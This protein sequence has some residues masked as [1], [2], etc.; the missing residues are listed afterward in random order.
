MRKDLIY[1]KKFP[2]LEY[3]IENSGRT[4]EAL[5]DLIGISPLSMWRKRIGKTD[6]TVIEAINL[7]NNLRTSLSVEE[8]FKEA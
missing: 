7:K 5:A 2:N 8:L 4:A 3:A 1:D 6:F